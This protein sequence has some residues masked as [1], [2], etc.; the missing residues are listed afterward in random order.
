MER[1]HFYWIRLGS[2]GQGERFFA[3]SHD[4]AIWNVLGMETGTFLVRSLRTMAIR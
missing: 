1:R 4:A 3:F 2:R